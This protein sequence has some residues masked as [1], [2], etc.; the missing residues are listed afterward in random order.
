M[1]QWRRGVILYHICLNV[2]V[3]DVEELGLGS[4]RSLDIAAVRSTT[5]K[6]TDCSVRV[7]R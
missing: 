6:L 3:L 4:I 1:L 2:D 7:Y 5:V